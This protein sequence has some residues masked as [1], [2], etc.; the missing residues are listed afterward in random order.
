MGALGGVALLGLAPLGAGAS[1]DQTAAVTKTVSF[2]VNLRVA[3]PGHNVVAWKADGQANFLHHAAQE[4]VT[5]PNM[6]LHANGILPG[7]KAVQ[8]V[9][10]WVGDK[11]YVTV[12]S[13]ISGLS[14]APKALSVPV[15]AARS[16]E[17]DLALDQSAVALTY[18]K[19]LLNE[20][21]QQKDQHAVSPRKIGGVPVN[22]TRVAL[23]LTDLLKV[24]PG[25]SPTMTG[26]LTMF[27]NDSIPVTLWIDHKGRLVEATMG[28]DPNG[29][30]ASVT[31]V[32][33]FSHYNDPVTISA[34]A[35]ATVA[36]MP[37]SV[38]QIL[39]GLQFF[40]IIPLP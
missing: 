38:S 32:I 17:I 18:T 37:A 10:K 23:T 28:G 34:P 30:E 3:T 4:F 35:P 9:A 7:H 29:H 31:G 36:A 26:D 8:M 11:A 25:L 13:S 22:G 21:A 1:S 5:L 33:E 40:D 12:P 15:G 39:S 20:L 19:V 14:G 16:H 24:S 6:G 2:A 27:G